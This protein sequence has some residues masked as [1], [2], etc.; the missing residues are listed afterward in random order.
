VDYEDT[1][2]LIVYAAAWPLRSGELERPMTDRLCPACHVTRQSTERRGIEID[3]CPNCR[4]VWLDRGELDKLLNREAAS[5]RRRAAA[6]SAG[7]SPRRR[8]STWR[9]LFD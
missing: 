4:G 6:D 5:T 1:R 2:F 7:E 3:V 9:D 8:R